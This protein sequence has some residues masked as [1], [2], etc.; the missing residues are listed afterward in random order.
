MYPLGDVALRAPV[1]RPPSIRFFEDGRTFA[2]GNTASINGPEDAS[3]TP[4]AVESRFSAGAVI[5]HDEE[6]AG[7]TL[8]N[9]WRAP[10]PTRQDRGFAMLVGPRI[11]TDYVPEFDFA[12]AREV[13]ARNTR[14]RAATSSLRR[15][16]R[17]TSRK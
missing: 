9:D 1:L 8:V 4:A 2:F 17:S 15:R 3:P 6:I 7:Y 12:S 14:L 10:S 5:G 16:S 13:A 11:E